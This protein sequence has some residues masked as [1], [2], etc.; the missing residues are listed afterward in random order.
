MDENFVWGLLLGC[1]ISLFV[2]LGLMGVSGDFDYIE[3]QLDLDRD[4]LARYHV[5]K[6]YPE[7]ENCS[8]TYEYNLEKPRLISP[9]IRGA[10]V[11]CGVSE[12]R[13]GMKIVKGS[14]K[15]VDIEFEDVSFK[16]IIKEIVKE[17]I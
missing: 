12:D 3:D 1:F 11:S 4:D 8:I 9:V 17:N 7:Y 2:I 10:R 16:E 13:D 14:S 15:T 5:L 6:Y